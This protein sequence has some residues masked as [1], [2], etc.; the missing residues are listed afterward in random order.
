MARHDVHPAPDGRGYLLDVQTDLLG[1]LNTRVVVPLMP[2]DAAPEPARL[3]NP[4]FEVDGEPHVMA[5]QFLSAVPAGVLRP[6]TASLAARA[7]EIT[8][9]LDMLFQGF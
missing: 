6:P 8:R 9:A 4:L 1:G 2:R 3:L 5:T 7:E